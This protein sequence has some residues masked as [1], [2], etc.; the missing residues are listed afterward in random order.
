MNRIN[1]VKRRSL[2]NCKCSDDETVLLVEMYMLDSI[3]GCLTLER[4]A[5]IKIN[6]HILLTIASISTAPK[7]VGLFGAH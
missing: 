3:K 2:L 1:Y 6:H 4:Q 5:A 7:A